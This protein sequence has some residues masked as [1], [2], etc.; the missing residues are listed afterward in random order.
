MST[1]YWSS[2]SDE[3][4]INGS[5]RAWLGHLVTEMAAIAWDLDVSVNTDQERIYELLDMSPEPEAGPYG[6]NYL[7]VKLREARAAD[8]QYERDCARFEEAHP[9]APA[10]APGRPWP[11]TAPLNDLRRS[12]RTALSTGGIPLVVAGHAM[13]SIE[14][15]LN[16]VLVVGSDLMALAAKVNAWCES[17]AWIDGPDRAW[18]ADLIEKGLDA[19]VYRRTLREYDQGW[20]DVVAMLRR[21]DD[22]PVVLHDSSG[23]W[24]PAAEFAGVDANEWENLRDA[25]RW[26]AALTVLRAERPWA[27]LAPDTLSTVRFLHG[28]TIY[29]LFAP[30]RDERVHRAFA[31]AGAEASGE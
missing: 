6:A 19:G 30:D 14:V 3:A 25:Q 27:R 24:F 18:M 8:A 31:A 10:L 5:E 1:V 12:L 28:L 21:R 20:T 22:E 13:R 16:T 29:D 2:L 11:D 9:S 15:W 26:D 17:H 7:H 4:G 23:N